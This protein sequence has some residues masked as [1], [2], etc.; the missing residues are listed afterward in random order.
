MFTKTDTKNHNVKANTLLATAETVFSV[1]RTKIFIQLELEN[2]SLI[3]CLQRNSV[4]IQYEKYFGFRVRLS[5][6]DYIYIVLDYFPNLILLHLQI[7]PMSPQPPP[8]CA[9]SLYF[10]VSDCIP[11]L[12]GGVR[13]TPGRLR[14]DVSDTDAGDCGL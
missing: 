12:L 3:C 2:T 1:M 7:Q 6:V 8:H 5:M 10:A 9:A 4:L 11:Q 13:G 14:G